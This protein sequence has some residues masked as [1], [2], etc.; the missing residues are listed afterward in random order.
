AVRQRQAQ[1]LLDRRDELLRNA[2][3]D[4]PVVKPEAALAGGQG[5]EGD[6]HAGK[7]AGTAGLFAV[8][9]LDLAG[10]RDRLTIGNAGGAKDG[11]HIV[12]LLQD[13]DADGQMQ[14]THAGEQRLAGLRVD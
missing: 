12:L 4:D 14:L 1:S 6:A 5:R 10:A 13:L 11:V 7:L 8:R 9:M 2:P 3:A